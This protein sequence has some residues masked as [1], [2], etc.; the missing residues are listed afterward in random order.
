MKRVKRIVSLLFCLAL[1]ASMLSACGGG[2]TTSEGTTEGTAQSSVTTDPN[3]DLSGKMPIIKDPSKFP[4]MKMLMVAEPALIKDPNELLQTQRLN[5]ETGVIFDW[6]T[7]PSEGASEKINLMLSSRDL[8]DVFWNGINN[9]ILVQYADQD[10]FIPT[11]E[12]TEKYVPNLVKIFEERPQYKALATCPNGH[13]YGFPYI[14]EMYGLVLTPGPFMINT[15]WLDKLG[16]PMPTTIEE[17]EN[18]LKAFKA[19]GDLN[20]NGKNDEVPYALG[21]GA[22]DT[23][24]SYNTFNQFTACFGQSDTY[25]GRMND[26]MAVKDDKIIFTAADDAYKETAKWFHQLNSE[27]LI[28]PDSFSPG[29]TPSSPLFLNKLKGSEAVIGSFGL[30]AP[31]NEIPDPSVYKQYKP[32]P[33][34]KGPKGDMGHALNFSEMH[35]AGYTTITTACKYPEVVAAWVN[36]ILEPELSITTNWGPVGYIYVKGDDGKLHFDL[37]PDGTFKLKD[38]F[39]TFGEM[40]VNSTPIKGSPIVLNEYYDKYA[41][42][43]WDAVDL[44][45]AQRVNGKDDVLKEGHP[46]P[47]MLLTVEEART[48]AQI[49][50]QLKN[51]VN[52]YTMQ[53]ILDGKVDETWEKYKADLDAAGLKE[54]L[55]TY[56]KAYDRYLSNIKK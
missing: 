13:R 40:R 52:S 2:E 30:W 29:T 32:L 50:P 31:V 21:L 47:M 10:V 34:L 5:K 8:P 49:Q 9:D 12:L 36:H 55:A 1:L 20:G 15:A 24:G 38:G 45:A 26:H 28:D 54:F 35:Y 18:A 16:L 23:F 14:E 19:A 22:E 56:Q 25:G 46:V 33:R 41:D 6:E 39:K 3:I 51:I 4:K 44:L 42:Y 7:I 27:G 17:W 43:T 37:N 11:E 53:W 48:V